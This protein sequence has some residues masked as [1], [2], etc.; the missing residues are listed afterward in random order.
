MQKVTK[1]PIGLGMNH[2][3]QEIAACQLYNAAIEAGN[4]WAWIPVKGT[5]PD[6]FSEN[7]ETGKSLLGSGFIEVENDLVRLTT[8]AIELIQ[9]FVSEQ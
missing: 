4:L 9:K 1:M 3:E 6:L 5:N 8:K 7:R 2:L